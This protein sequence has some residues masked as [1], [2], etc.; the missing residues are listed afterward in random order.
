MPRKKAGCCK[1]DDLMV[2]L[3][4]SKDLSRAASPSPT[5]EKIRTCYEEM[6]IEVMPPRHSHKVEIDNCERNVK[7]LIGFMRLF[8]DKSATMLNCTALKA[9]PVHAVHLNLS[10][11]K[12]NG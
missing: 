4:C 6:R 9:Y 1:N 3:E 5:T 10:A 11:K 7:S 8:Y 12:Y 2:R